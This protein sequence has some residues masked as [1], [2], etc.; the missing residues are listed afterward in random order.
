[1]S[2]NAQNN[3]STE[4]SEHLLESSNIIRSILIVS[5]PMMLSG[6]VDALYNA[7]DSVFVGRF[8][9]EL[10]LAALA[11]N[12][13]IQIFLI[14]VGSLFG[15]GA[16]SLISRALG[17]KNTTKV[18]L[19]LINS[20]VVGFIFGV[21]ISI[22][23][24]YFLDTIL[25]FMGSSEN[26]LY[27]SREYAQVILLGGF[28]QPLNT[29]TLAILRAK[30]LVKNVMQLVVLGAFSNI[31]LDA[32]F[33]IYFQ[34]GVAGAAFATILSQFVILVLSLLQI[35]K[36]Y[37]FYFTFF[38]LRRISWKICM[39]I[40]SIGV[41][42]FS[43]VCTFVLMATAANRVLSSYGPAMVAG[44]GI[45]NRI[46]HLAYQP[47][48]G[49]NLGTQTLIGYNYG[50]NRFLKVKNIIL[51]GMIFSTII[52]LLP[53]IILSTASE[54]LFYI[55]TDSLDVVQFARQGANIVGLTFFLYGF[56]VFASGSLVAMGHPTQALILSLFRPLVLLVL[57]L[58]LP[59]FFQQ[60]GVWYAFFMTDI[61]N[62]LFSALIIFRELNIL[63]KKHLAYSGLK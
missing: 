56:Q 18:R 57:T 39:E 9:G 26:V 30:G 53:S 1:M 31:C 29:I 16:G 6:F 36:S 28:I 5:V 25:V 46:L 33:I 41:T 3:S 54:K 55:F 19:V 45:V 40:L 15:V 23:I 2:D 13:I 48:F 24:L 49:S 59:K 4:N 14:A 42:H 43:R 61:L 20:L 32:V 44:Y 27:F 11:I 60:T 34:W 52:G 37:L 10:A 12:N 58:I 47:I 21:L 63:K 17:A 35:K 38:D 8:V 7:V 51:K 22:L 50:A 62:T